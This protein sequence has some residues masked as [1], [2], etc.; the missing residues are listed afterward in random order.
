MIADPPSPPAA[1]LDLDAIFAE[2]RRRYR[3][4]PYPTARE[5]VARLE[6]LER[7]ILRRRGALERALLADFRKPPEETA[8]SELIVTLVEL[9]HA[10]A[11][12][13]TWMR[14]EPVEASLATFGSK[15]EVRFEP[16]GVVLIMAPWNYPF[17]LA[18]APL[19]AAIAAGCRAIVRP[20]EKTPATRDVMAQ[21]VQEAFEPHEVAL[22]GGEID[23]AQKLLQLPFDHFFFT[24]GTAVGKLVMKAAAE[25]LASV[26]LEL[27]GK[28]PC[29]V[30]FD[31]DL[32]WAAK[33]IAFG[34][35]YNGGQT[36][37]APDYALVHAS[38]ER[39]FIERL[40]GAVE[41]MY[42]RSDAER[43]ATPDFARIVDDGHF[44]RVCG[45][46][47]DSVR[48]GAIVEL[49]GAADAAERY[50]APTILSNVTFDAPIMREE[51]FGPVL[52]VLAF[53]SL[54]EALVQI[55]AR[56]K[57]LALYIFSKK[58]K[59]ADRVIDATSAGGTLVNDTLLHFAHPN[60]PA[61]GIGESGTGNYHGRFGFRAFSHERAVMRQSKATLAPQLAAPYTRK[62][63]SMLAML[64]K[65]P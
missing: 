6:R 40:K 47:D 25:H 52:P 17:Q 42:G 35:F 55:N 53:R 51:I 36:C 10:K 60:L 5:R 58:P 41:K 62:T 26:T 11:N 4:N 37:V 29:I 54:D 39:P 38:V 18:M 64:E 24:G 65:L 30:D 50:I 14:P 9:R 31:A 45:L 61:G 56:P 15:S 28:S 59:T 22:V 19:I 23:V 13:A 32:D 16:K 8:F 7:A 34:K 2:Q 1:P 21:I 3:E 46:V 43:K 63:R 12:L 44:A 33:R 27:G 49:G 48:G 57:P 20:S